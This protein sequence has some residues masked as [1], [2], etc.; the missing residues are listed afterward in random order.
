MARIPDINCVNWGEIINKFL[1]Q[2]LD[3][4][5]G[6]INIWT[7]ENRPGGITGIAGIEKGKCGW[8]ITKGCLERFDGN[9]WIELRSQITEV[10]TPLI[11][12]NDNTIPNTEWVNQ[13]V[14]KIVQDF[15]TNTLDSYISTRVKEIVRDEIIP[16]VNLIMETYRTLHDIA[17][18]NT[19]LPVEPSITLG[20][21]KEE[22]LFDIHIT[23]DD[24]I[25]AP[26][27]IYVSVEEDVWMG[28]DR[29]LSKD[30]N[31]NTLL[32]PIKAQQGL[33]FK[34]GT[35]LN[36]S[37]EPNWVIHLVSNPSTISQ[38]TFKSRII[39]NTKLNTILVKD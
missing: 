32:S 15:I 21:S 34:S 25:H 13:K 33:Y 8:N 22:G 14:N 35:L 2:A 1:T 28:Y 29:F 37:I 20:H 24:S 27:G 9:R 39:A 7:D 12:S 23:F 17:R 5:S 31:G 38:S 4:E 36:V 6:S 18:S 30:L 10:S 19:S 11:T 26:V 16:E 3:P